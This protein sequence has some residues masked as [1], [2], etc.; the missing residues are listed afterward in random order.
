[1]NADQ[2]KNIRRQG[3]A[4]RGQKELIKHLSDERLTL[5][6]AVNAYCY[7]C[8]GFYADGK[9]DCMMKNCPLHPFMAFN[10]NRG[11]K[12]TSRPVSAEHMQKMREA[13]L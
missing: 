10:Q 5:K 3:K 8:T 12:T 1:M 7:S 6:Q 13:R 2:I 9:T 4:A 11:K